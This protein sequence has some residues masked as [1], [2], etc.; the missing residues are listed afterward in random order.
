MSS[1]FSFLIGLLV[2]CT[3]LSCTSL[4]ALLTARMRSLVVVIFFSVTQDAPLTT[5]PWCTSPDMIA[6]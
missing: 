5:N 1:S 4:A 6:Q 2:I 3:I